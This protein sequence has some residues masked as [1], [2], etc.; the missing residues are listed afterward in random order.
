VDIFVSK[1]MLTRALDFASE[2][3]LTIEDRRHSVRLLPLGQF[4]RVELHTRPGQRP[5]DYH[6]RE[7]WSPDRATIASIGTVAI[8]LTIFEISEEADFRYVDGNY[9][10]VSDLPVRRRPYSDTFNWI[11]KRETGSGRLAVRA[12][13]PY[14]GTTWTQDWSESKPGDLESKMR[15]IRKSIEAA[16]PLIVPMIEEAQRQREEESRRWAAERIEWDRKERLRMEQEARE[17]SRS[18]LM[19]MIANWTE[20]CGIESFFD[21]ATRRASSLPS[22]ERDAIAGRIADAR[23]LLNSTDPLATLLGWLSPE[24]R[25][26]SKQDDSG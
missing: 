17:R 18:E 21:D 19:A 9:V 10:R 13:S 11:S 8:G 14:P 15:A 24:Q 22:E 16:A 25:L 3:F 6:R 26:R 4:R 1:A 2:L 5:Y 23:R 7:P 12:Y 20:A